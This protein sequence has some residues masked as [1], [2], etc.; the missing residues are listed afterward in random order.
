MSHWIKSEPLPGGG[1]RVRFSSEVAPFWDWLRD[2]HAQSFLPRLLRDKKSA[3]DEDTTRWLEE[4]RAEAHSERNQLFRSLDPMPTGNRGA[5][6]LRLDEER[7]HLLLQCI[8]DIRMHAWH[9]LGCPENLDE[10][11]LE[12]ANLWNYPDDPRAVRLVFEICGHLIG[13]ITGALLAED[14]GTTVA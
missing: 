3:P 5:I 14:S 12:D 8:N 4:A 7:A 13:W 10:L 1:I 11:K 2:K 6:E 9:L